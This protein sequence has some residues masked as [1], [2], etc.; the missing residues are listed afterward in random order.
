MSPTP[1]S[2]QFVLTLQ[3]LSNSYS[4]HSLL[5]SQSAEQCVHSHSSIVQHI[6]TKAQLIPVV[7]PHKTRCVEEKKEKSVPESR[8]QHLC[9]SDP[10]CCYRLH[11]HECAV[12][13]RGLLKFACWYLTKGGARAQGGPDVWARA[14]AYKEAGAVI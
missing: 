13:G 9:S 12:Q 14:K 10:R 2:H 5:I 1:A 11:E 7:A 3:M 6:I 8:S 4:S